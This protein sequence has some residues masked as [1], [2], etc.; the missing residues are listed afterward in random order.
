MTPNYS[1]LGLHRSSDPFPFII[2]FSLETS[3]KPNWNK[4]GTS[5]MINKVGSYRN[6]VY[7]FRIN[8]GGGFYVN[9][10]AV[11]IRHLGLLL[12]PQLRWTYV[13]GFRSLESFHQELIHRRVVQTNILFLDIL[14]PKE[15]QSSFDQDPPMDQVSNL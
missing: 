12:R 7:N 15:L 13:S 4:P 6:T 5:D 1:L 2:D 9:R 14:S 3:D 8:R 10:R 11:T